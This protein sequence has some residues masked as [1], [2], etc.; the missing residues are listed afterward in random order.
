MPNCVTFLEKKKHLIAEKI[1]RL[2]HL[3]I[4][5]ESICVV[6]ILAQRKKKNYTRETHKLLLQFDLF[7]I[8]TIF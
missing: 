5:Q 7:T 6:I 3:I 2:F 4:Q 8:S 1:F